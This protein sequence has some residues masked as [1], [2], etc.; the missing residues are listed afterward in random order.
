M[1]VVVPTR[2]N[3]Y[4]NRYVYN[5]QSI[6]NQNYTNYRIVVVDDHSEDKT[7]VLIERYLRRRNIST[8]RAVVLKNNRREGSL[9]NIHHAVHNYCKDYTVTIEVDGDDELI[10]NYVFKLFNAIYQS[11]NP[12]FAYSNHVYYAQ[13]EEYISKGYS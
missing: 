13:D 4:D 10:G 7:A 12:G 5:I 2:N 6:L 3:V 8:Q 11:K 1:C 9:A